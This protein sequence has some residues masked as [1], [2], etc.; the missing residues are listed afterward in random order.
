[1][2][3]KVGKKR[4]ATMAL[5]LIAIIGLVVPLITGVMASATP[6]AL[7]RVGDAGKFVSSSA[8]S[9]G[10]FT[11][12]S[13]TVQTSTGSIVVSGAL[14]AVRGQGL[15]VED[16]L[17]SGVQLC[18]QTTPATCAFVDGQWTGN[19]HSVQDQRHSVTWLP[20]RI[21]VDAAAFWFLVGLV[22]TVTALVVQF[23]ADKES[24]PPASGTTLPDPASGGKGPV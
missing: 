12:T 6:D 19:M 17:K 16:R 9:G 1:M 8:S 18:V 11:P 5:T 4:K 3:A 10:L 20:A 7:L 13:T 14:S 24:T 22:A 21:G 15:L 23:D 2:A